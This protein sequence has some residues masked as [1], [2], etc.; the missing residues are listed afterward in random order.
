MALKLR[1]A[2]R[3]AKKRP[4]YHIVVA[5]ATA[6]RDGRFI[7]KVG[8]YNPMVAKDSPLRITLD[9]PRIRHWLSVGALPTDRVERFL[10]DA[11]I[12]AMPVQKNSLLKAL[13]IK[14]AQERKAAEEAEKLKPAEVVAPVVEAAVAAEPEAPVEEAEAPKEA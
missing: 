14:R 7:E 12:L 9:E 5:E 13:P 6:P 1:L 4:F 3:G 10:G 8:T 11:N 2:R